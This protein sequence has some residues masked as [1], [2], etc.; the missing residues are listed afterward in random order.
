MTELFKTHLNEF[1][2]AP[3]KI[4]KLKFF[5]IQFFGNC[6]N[7]CILTSRGFSLK[8]SHETPITSD[9]YYIARII[10]TDYTREKFDTL[11]KTGNPT[12]DEPLLFDEIATELANYLES[13][14][15]S[16]LF[17]GKS[18][19]GAVA[20]YTAMKTKM[21]KYLALQCPAP[22]VTY[23]KINI[24]M[25]LGWQ[26][27]DIKVDFTKYANY[28]KNQFELSDSQCCFTYADGNHVLSPLFINDVLHFMNFF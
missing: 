17:I 18:V 13:E 23:K 4:D 24:P 28:T 7:P 16:C 25:F 20:Y 9:K 26:T 15:I 22:C 12:E 10:Y 11:H 8:A 21:I 5:E 2:I 14:K 6:K 19:G 27:T 1:K 3:E